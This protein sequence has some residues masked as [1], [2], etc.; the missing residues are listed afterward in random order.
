MVWIKCEYMQVQLLLF[1]KFQS[2]FCVAGFYSNWE[3]PSG[4]AVFCGWMPKMSENSVVSQWCLNYFFYS[5]AV[6]AFEKCSWMCG[7]APEEAA[8]GLSC[9]SLLHTCSPYPDNRG[10]F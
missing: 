9:A 4:R 3:E 8:L 10:H 5:L 2:Q 1:N 6:I 7:A